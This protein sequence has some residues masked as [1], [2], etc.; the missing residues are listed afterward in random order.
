MTNICSQANG[1]IQV[2]P[3]GLSSVREQWHTYP[4]ELLFAINLVMAKW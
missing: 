3:F 1:T 4:F 2:V